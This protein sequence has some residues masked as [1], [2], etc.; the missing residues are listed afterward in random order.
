MVARLDVVRIRQH[1]TALQA[2]AHFGDIVLEAAE[3]GDRRRRDD[4]VLT[5]ETRVEAL[6]DRT[7]E[8]QQA[9][10]LVALAGREDF[11]DLGA[12]DDGLDA[13]GSELARPLLRDLLDR[14]GNTPNPIH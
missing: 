13:F 14:K 8:H 1:D 6:A 11:L 7:F 10:S 12:P 9:R 2:R 5:R 3:R 4:D